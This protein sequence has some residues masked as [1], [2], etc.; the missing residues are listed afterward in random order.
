MLQPTVTVT[1][2][3]GL[4]MLTLSSTALLLIVAEPEP[5]GVHEKLQFAW[6]V[7]GCHVVPPSTETSTPATT[8]PPVSAAV[9]VIDTAVPG[10]R[11]EP[12]A[13]EVIVELGAIA[14]ADAVAAVT[15]HCTV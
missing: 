10:G 15:P 8:P 9:P 11:F 13:G 4:S 14:S 5:A 12:A 7:A 2:A 3:L 6:P 1:P